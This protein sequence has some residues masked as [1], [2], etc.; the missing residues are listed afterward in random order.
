M[1][2]KTI[3]GVVVTGIVLFFFG[4]LYWGVN[5]LPY[6]TWNTV[7][8]PAVAQTTA[9]SLF[10]EDGV[11]FLPG[12]GNDPEAAK[13][14]ETG[15]SVMLTIRHTQDQMAMQF[16]LGVVHNILSALLLVI[17]LKGVVG[18]GAMITRALLVGFVAGFVILGSNIIWWMQPISWM[19]FHLVY[20]LIYF[21]L[22]AWV[23]SFFL[24]KAETAS[25]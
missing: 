18:T 25:A 13:L 7:T 11:Y 3:L 5:Q 16:G 15:P 6:A 19:F 9:A 4:F 1:G 17:V 21:A 12:P 10:P 8:D 14:L 22:G 23:L 2:G 20:Y 24:P